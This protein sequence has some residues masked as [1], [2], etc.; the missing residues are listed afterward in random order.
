MKLANAWR[1]E[2]KMGWA[3]EGKARKDGRSEAGEGRRR[4]ERE[5]LRRGMAG[6]G[7]RVQNRAGQGRSG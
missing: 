4:E 3:G 1:K 2:M 7:R 5:R 6:H